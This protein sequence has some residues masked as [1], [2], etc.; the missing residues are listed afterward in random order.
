MDAKVTI[1]H[2]FHRFVFQGEGQKER[3]ESYAIGQTVTVSQEDAA[4]WMTKGLAEAAE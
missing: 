4:D 1:T 3:K 2:T